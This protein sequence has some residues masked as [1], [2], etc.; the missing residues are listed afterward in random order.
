MPPEDLVLIYCY[1]Y[2]QMHT[3]SGFHMFVRNLVDYKSEILN[4]LVFVDFGCGPLTCGISLA[5]YNYLASHNQKLAATGRAKVSL[6]RDRSKQGY[7]GPCPKMG[8]GGRKLVPQQVNIRFRTSG[9]RFNY[10]TGRLLISTGKPMGLTD[11]RL[12]QLLLPFWQP[13]A[14]CRAAR[15]VHQRLDA[16][17]FV[18]RQS[19]SHS[20]ERQPL[21]CEREVEGIQE[22]REDAFAVRWRSGRTDTILRH[23]W[24][25]NPA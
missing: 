7:V 3:V 25:Q 17:A 8:N 11:S 22:G 13:C 6:H 18:R 4:N 20:P 23:Y 24:P 16:K 9:Q 19:L 1:R 2:M 14:K 12:L 10:G 5:W 15:K 21:G